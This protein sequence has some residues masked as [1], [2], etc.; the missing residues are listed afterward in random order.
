MMTCLLRVGRVCHKNIIIQQ[1]QKHQI[2]K[3]CHKTKLNNLCGQRYLTT[4]DSADQHGSS[5]QTFEK[6]THFG[7]QTVTEE[8]KYKK[9]TVLHSISHCV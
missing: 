6:K 3:R 9:G 4:S 5:E 2:S 1:L 8:E 7:F